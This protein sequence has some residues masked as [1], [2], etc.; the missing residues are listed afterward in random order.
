[1]LANNMQTITCGSGSCNGNCSPGFADCNTNKR[2]DGCEINTQTNAAHCNMCGRNCTSICVGNVAST[3]CSGGVC[4]VLSCNSGFLN[5]N[6]TCSD[7]CECQQVL[8]SASCGAPTSL[9][10]INVG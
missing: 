9:G 3:S 5:L 10:T 8:P 2:T 7:G 1:M 6:G 4:S